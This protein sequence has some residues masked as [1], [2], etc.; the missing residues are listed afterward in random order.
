MWKILAFFAG[1]IVGIV[2]VFVGVHLYYGADNY[3]DFLSFG[4]KAA[5]VVTAAFTGFA[6]LAAV[7]AVI[8]AVRQLKSKNDLTS[9]KFVVNA[10]HVFVSDKEMSALFSM[11]RLGTLKY[12]DMTYEAKDALDRLLLHFASVVLAYKR[13]LISKEDFGFILYDLLRVAGNP[14]VNA[15]IDAHLEN[16]KQTNP[17]CLEMHPYRVIQQFAK[18]YGEQGDKRCWLWRKIRR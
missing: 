7:W 12:E 6:A 16:V 2:A 14:E 1:V 4:A 15:Y 13:E 5:P 8:V 18:D 3:K 17:R 11:I 10:V 9:V